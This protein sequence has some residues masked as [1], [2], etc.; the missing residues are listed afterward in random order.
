MA[1]AVVSRQPSA[2]SPQTTLERSESASS[3]TT[4]QASQHNGS[5]QTASSS[6]SAQ[7]LLSDSSSTAPKSQRTSASSTRAPDSYQS[8]KHR[9]TAQQE[10]QQ[11]V[12]LAPAFES[13]APT[14]SSGRVGRDG[15]RNRG[16]Y[17]RSESPS[18]TARR[19]EPQGWN[20]RYASLDGEDDAFGAHD[21]ETPMSYP[22]FDEETK[23][24][25]KIQ[26]VRAQ[27]ETCVVLADSL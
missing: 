25:R 7:T 5:V 6:T 10:Q 14:A 4:I 18:S 15:E 20:D 23:E 12:A 11:Q 13:E 16:F 2:Q 1:T 17:H 27:L 19:R 21:E 24:A 9:Y 26:Q 8:H 3:T 22:P